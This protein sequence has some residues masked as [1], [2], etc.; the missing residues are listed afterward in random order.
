MTTHYISAELA[1]ILDKSTV[2]ETHGD[3]WDCQGPI[4]AFS[5]R[6]FE[7]T[8]ELYEFTM[9]NVEKIQ[10]V[11]ARLF[12]LQSMPPTPMCIQKVHMKQILALE[13]QWRTFTRG[14][15][16]LLPP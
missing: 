6:F 9:I 14:I 13:V 4:G 7:T 10:E 5:I 11:R 3:I 16:A 2:V 8:A 12:L 15:L 1:I